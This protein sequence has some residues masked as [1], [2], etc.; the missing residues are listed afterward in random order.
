MDYTSAAPKPEF[1]FCY[2]KG[3]WD[4][5]RAAFDFIDFRPSMDG[6]IEW[7]RNKH[8][9]F[10]LTKFLD[11]GRMGFTEEFV[12]RLCAFALSESPTRMRGSETATKRDR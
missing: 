5:H 7:G 11:Y 2:G 9:V 6:A 4:E 12:D 8:T 10:V 1:V 3:F